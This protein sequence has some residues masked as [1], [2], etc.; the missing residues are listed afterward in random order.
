L[1][2][3]DRIVVMS[4]GRIVF[5][6]RAAIADRQVLGAHMGGGAALDAQVVDTALDAQIVDTA[7]DAQ[8][9]DTALDAQGAGAAHGRSRRVAA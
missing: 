9:V 2:L 7:L 5:E 1:E 4:E 3:A 6:T 8:I